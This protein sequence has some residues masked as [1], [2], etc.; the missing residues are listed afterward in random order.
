[1]TNFKK[2][3]IVNCKKASIRKNPSCTSEKDD[4]IG[5]LEKG[6]LLEVDTST[7]VFDWTDNEYY[8]CSTSF[9]DGYILTE[10][11]EIL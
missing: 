7:R 10:I 1:M 2:A 4:V 9:G 5:V 11:V 8:K 6:E 3:R